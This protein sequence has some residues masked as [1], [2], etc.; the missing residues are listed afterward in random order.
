[1]DV[2]QQQQPFR[3]TYYNGT[4][5]AIRAMGANMLFICDN[6]HG[7]AIETKMFKQ[8]GPWVEK[9]LDENGYKPYAEEKEH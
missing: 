7:P 6:P 4:T 1:M 9:Y 8:Q 3:M 5:Y 2:L